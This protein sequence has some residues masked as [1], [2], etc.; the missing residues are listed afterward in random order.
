M[1]KKREAVRQGGLPYLPRH[2]GTASGASGHTAESG[3]R[4]EYV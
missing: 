3:A 1:I 2:G 4:Y